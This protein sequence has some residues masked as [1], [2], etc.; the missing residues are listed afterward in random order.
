MIWSSAGAGL[1]ADGVP[2]FLGFGSDY[3]TAEGQSTLL[4]TQSYKVA[5]L[6]RE[7]VLLEEQVCAGDDCA[8]DAVLRTALRTRE[9]AYSLGERIVLG[10]GFQQS[11]SG[12][13]CFRRWSFLFAS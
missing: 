11:L 7:H 6:E 2:A 3:S 1:G 4:I 9:L 12:R 5:D 13:S 8:L 10:E